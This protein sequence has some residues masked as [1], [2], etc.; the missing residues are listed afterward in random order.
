[1][2]WKNLMEK[3]REARKQQAQHLSIDGQDTHQDE[4]NTHVNLV[5][6][7]Q[8]VRDADTT[9]KW[10]RPSRRNIQAEKKGTKLKSQEESSERPD[11]F[12]PHTTHNTQ[13]GKKKKK[14]EERNEVLL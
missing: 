9:S 13:I 1:M 12:I 5:A 7:H 3:K 6:V 11:M 2:E 10:R 14:I 4:R 8:V